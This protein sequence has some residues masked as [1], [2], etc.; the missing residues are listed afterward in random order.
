VRE[1][2]WVTQAKRGLLRLWVNCTTKRRCRRGRTYRGYQ[3][4][5]YWARREK[6]PPAEAAREDAKC[7][8]LDAMLNIGPK[9]AQ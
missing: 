4:T 7:A 8:A 2:A 6:L 1:T 5:C 3:L 9:F